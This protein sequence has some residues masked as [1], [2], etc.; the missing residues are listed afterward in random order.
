MVNSAGI[1]GS[2]IFHEGH[3]GSSGS[4]HNEIG[5]FSKQII[6][7]AADIGEKTNANIANIASK[8]GLV[9]RI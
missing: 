6:G 7:L 8:N 3:I 5:A 1:G 2:E 4:F 9:T